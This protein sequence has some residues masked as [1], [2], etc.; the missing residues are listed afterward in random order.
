M[1]LEEIS[2][3]VVPT[4]VVEETVEALREAGREGFERFVVW[5]GSANG[6]EMVIRTAHSPQQTAYKTSAGLMVRVEGEALHKL[7]AWLYKNQHVLAVQVHAHPTDAFH[8]GID[9]QYPIV[10]V[11]GGLSIVVPDFAERGV[12]ARGLKGYRLTE[13]GWKRVWPPRFRRLLQ[14][15]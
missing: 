8:S 12:F 7:N 6:S 3:F 14:V 4:A 1:S 2:R 13:R 15:S 9:D 5:S 10:T 11:I